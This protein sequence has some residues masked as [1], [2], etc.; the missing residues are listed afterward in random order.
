[1]APFCSI[2]FC[3]E[4]SMSVGQVVARGALLRDVFACVKGKDENDPKK[5]KEKR[6]RIRAR[7]ITQ[8]ALNCSLARSA[9]KVLVLTSY[10]EVRVQY[11]TRTI[12]CPHSVR[13]RPSKQRLKGVRLIVIT[14]ILFNHLQTHPPA[15][16]TLFGIGRN[17]RHTQS[18]R[19]APQPPHT[20]TC[21]VTRARPLSQSRGLRERHDQEKAPNDGGGWGN[22][23]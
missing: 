15:R 13:M 23:G 18:P 1:M 14:Q 7:P 3:R 19:R 16:G 22:A 6:N 21:R 4:L 20:V 11:S 2:L 8:S 5:K 17:S 10:Y 9:L 12:F